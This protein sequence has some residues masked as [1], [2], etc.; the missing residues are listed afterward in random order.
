MRESQQIAT[1]QHGLASHAHRTG[2][3][4]R[5]QEDHLTGH[6][7]SRQALEH[8]RQAY[9]HTQARHG[10]HD[11]K[12]AEIAALA[13]RLWH[14]RGCP[15]GSPEHDWFRALEELRHRR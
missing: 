15:E 1:E 14:E 9:L 12:E 13:Y 8:S 7:S 11:V 2:A 3:E 5:G 6:E 10:A 4:H